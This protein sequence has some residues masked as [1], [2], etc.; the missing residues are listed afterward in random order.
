MPLI[1]F[2]VLIVVIVFWLIGIYNNIVKLRNRRENAFA[3][4]DVQLKQRHDLIPQLVE[5][6]KGSCDRFVEFPYDP[7]TLL[8]KHGLNRETYPDLV[9]NALGLKTNIADIIIDGGNAIKWKDC[10]TLTGKGIRGEARKCLKVKLII[11][12]ERYLKSRPLY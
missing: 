4:I 10:V 9:C 1:I 5:T 11:R 6:V 7:E 8:N 12:L 2:L 3:D